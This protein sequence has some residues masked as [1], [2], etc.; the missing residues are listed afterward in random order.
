MS[1]I[2]PIHRGK[3]RVTSILNFQTGSH[4]SY[5]PID[6]LSESLISEGVAVRYVTAVPLYVKVFRKMGMYRSPRRKINPVIVPMMGFRRDFFLHGS[7]IGDPIPFI[8]DSWECN[9]DRWEKFFLKS[10]VKKVMMTSSVSVKH[11]SQLFPD[12]EFL[13]V[14]E[15]IKLASYSNN[16]DLRLREIDILELGRKFDRWHNLVFQNENSGAFVHLYEPQV[17]SIIFESFDEML[18]GVSQARLFICFPQSE[19]NPERAGVVETMTQ[20]Y[21]EGLGS[22]CLVLGKAPQE[23]IDLFGY[24]PV[25]EVDW[26]DPL[27][28]VTTLL[29]NIEDYQDFCDK[30]FERVKTVG[31][32]SHRT[33]LIL[34][35]VTLKGFESP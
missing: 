33:N 22:G 10:K 13:Y 17:G 12:I 25:I 26:Q 8:W 20:R 1:K 6:T 9:W 2:H 35:F 21:L 31:D 27:G 18:V 30:N 19:T 14:P 34:D 29:A 5:V 24:N 23:L 3:T 7:F 16:R 28:Q 11:F 4:P 15:A 32:W